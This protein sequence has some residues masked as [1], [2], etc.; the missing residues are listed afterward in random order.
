MTLYQ[1][2]WIDNDFQC[3]KIAVFFNSIYIIYSGD[4][5]LNVGWTENC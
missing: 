2:N 1:S 5:F 4:F 3:G